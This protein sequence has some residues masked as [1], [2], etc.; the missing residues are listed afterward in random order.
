M[1]KTVAELLCISE[2]ELKKIV[3][4]QCKVDRVEFNHD[5]EFLPNSK[6]GILI[7]IYGNDEEGYP[8]ED[9]IPF[10]DFREIVHRYIKDLGW[11][12]Q[13]IRY[14]TIYNGFGVI[15]IVKKKST[16]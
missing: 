6:D 7:E 8:F 13:E 4:S 15:A 9:D 12:L 16:P 2:A 1:A 10:Y 14:F 3:C 5:P 11:I